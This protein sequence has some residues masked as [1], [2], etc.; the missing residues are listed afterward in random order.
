MVLNLI[1]NTDKTYYLNKTSRVANIPDSYKKG[2]IF[3]LK[4]PRPNINALG[5]SALPLALSDK[6]EKLPEG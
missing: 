3:L 2:R 6:T 1:T 4:K 5:V